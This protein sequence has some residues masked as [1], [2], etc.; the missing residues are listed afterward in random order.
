MNGKTYKIH[1]LWSLL[2]LFIVYS[3][4]SEA[5]EWQT[6]VKE[7]PIEF[8]F[9]MPDDGQASTRNKV[10]FA[11]EDKV[12]ITAKVKTVDAGNVE[13]TKVVSTILNCQGGKFQPASGSDRLMWPADAVSAEFR[14]YYLP[15]THSTAPTA[16]SPLTIPLN[17]LKED[18]TND[19]LLLAQ[20]E[21]INLNG[22]VT[23][24]FAHTTTKLRF[25]GL[26]KEATTLKLVPQNISI[27]NQLVV[28]YS[29][30]DGYTH[31]F[32]NNTTERGITMEKALNE[33][34]ALFFLNVTSNWEGETFEF[35]QEGS[36]S[37][38]PKKTVLA[39]ASSHLS[40]MKIGRAYRLT[41]YS[42]GT[43]PALEK[44]DA[45]YKDHEI[46]TFQSVEEIQSYFNGEGKD[47]L[48]KDLDFNNILLDE[49]IPISFSSTRGIALTGTFNG[50]NHTIRN[51]YVRNG[52]FN[53][54]PS[55][56][57]I[58]N[59]RLENV[60]VIAENGEAAGLLSPSNA[61][62][63]DN[64][65]IG[66][67]NQIGTNNV[68]SVG[69]LVGV[70]TGTI[71]TVQLSGALLME[72]YIENDTETTK[73]F[74]VGG[75]VGSNTGTITNCE[76]N[77]GGLLQP[78]GTY[79]AGQA[80]IGGMV[81]SH[82]GANAIS[83]CSTFVRVDATRLAAKTSYV[84]G[85]C[86][87]NRGKLS[88]NEANGEVRGSLFVSRSATGG[89]L[90]FT[91]SSAAVVNGCGATGNVTESACDRVAATP[92]LYTG[93]FCGFSE[94][95]LKN[96]YSVG[97]LMSASS[98]PGDAVRRKGALTGLISAD[99]TVYN[100]FSI[101]N[102]GGEDLTLSGSEDL[103]NICKTQNVH[104]RGKMV[105]EQGVVETTIT[106]TIARLNNAV[107][108]ANGYWSWSSSS[109]IYG[110]VPY[111]VK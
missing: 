53:A 6:E 92:E 64:V 37:E 66:G 91:T 2:L 79:I 31:K 98:V 36:S 108:T 106:A 22:I 49:S 15:E 25:N 17:K 65:R 55:G 77:A 26:K 20:Q 94:I 33:T 97:A 62:T 72:P 47:G 52:L 40:T 28:S 12:Y 24:R 50:N 21:I 16:G 46:E 5:D 14:A 4:S 71:N 48:T 19:D 69:G 38:L 76:I 109:A 83:G 18:G 85:F 70:N 35:T 10:T 73:V 90:G 45:W 78:A 60:K 32:E 107:S 44:E 57:T 54:I 99:K 88:D 42:G 59:L 63:I 74:A 103:A 51:V 43:N 86:G 30:A 84:G 58:K 3:C 8:E 1:T 100:S 7:T 93:G 61:G 95:D 23:L 81:G 13:S 67:S 104:L 27:I 34:T 11:N 80:T 82:T 29:D 105:S 56:A 110:G 102:Q 68:S 75:L 89:F 101:T 9:L 111:I 39:D 41:F 87:V 96:V